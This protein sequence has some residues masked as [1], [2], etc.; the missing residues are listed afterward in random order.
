[1]EISSFSRAS[2]SIVYNNPQGVQTQNK[3]LHNILFC[4]LQGP[5]YK[6]GFKFY[7]CITNFEAIVTPDGS[8]IPKYLS[9]F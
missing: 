7:I 3:N 9:R 1:M 8:P 4:V 6:S 2:V 5:N